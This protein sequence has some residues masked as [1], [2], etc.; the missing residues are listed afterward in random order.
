MGC[1]IFV[2]AV[3]IGYGLLSLTTTHDYAIAGIVALFL[4]A[5]G[6]WAIEDKMPKK[7]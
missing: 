1:L 5:A 7:P 6:V 4:I 2:L 3:A